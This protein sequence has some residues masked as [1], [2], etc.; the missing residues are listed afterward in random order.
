MDMRELELAAEPAD[1]AGYSDQRQRMIKIA[2]QLFEF[3]L[4][5][6]S[7]PC[8]IAERCDIVSERLWEI[9]LE[10]RRLRLVSCRE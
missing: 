1:V 7:T 4:A 3:T 2:R 8:A 5:A 9:A 10:G 6:E